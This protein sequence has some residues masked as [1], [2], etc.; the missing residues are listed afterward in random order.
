MP[1]T[2]GST[3][4]VLRALACRAVAGAIP[5]LRLRSS[6]LGVVCDGRGPSRFSAREREELALAAG[7][8]GVGDRGREAEGERGNVRFELYIQFC[9][10]VYLCVFRRRDQS[11]LCLLKGIPDVGIAV[12]ALNIDI[13]PHRKIKQQRICI[14]AFHDS[15][16]PP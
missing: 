7:E 14:L 11:Y 3:Q 4:L 5:S 2:A 10:L 9:C 13:L 12:Q 15:P 8:G 16:T 1:S 6:Q